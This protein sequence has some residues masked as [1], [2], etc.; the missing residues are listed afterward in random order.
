MWKLAGW[1]W[2]GSVSNDERTETLP[3]HCNELFLLPSQ[4]QC[5]PADENGIC[6]EVP[7]PSQPQVPLQVRRAES[8]REE[9]LPVSGRAERLK[10]Q[11]HISHLCI[12]VKYR[13]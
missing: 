3:V 8:E 13:F 4:V 12:F 10:F 5:S 11:G 1:G 9:E 6:H 7:Q 2:G